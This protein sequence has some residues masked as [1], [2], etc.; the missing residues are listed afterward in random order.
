MDK[1]FIIFCIPGNRAGLLSAEIATPF[2]AWVK[3]LKG[4]DLVKK[5]CLKPV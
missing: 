3:G 1:I 5:I 4:K 2:K